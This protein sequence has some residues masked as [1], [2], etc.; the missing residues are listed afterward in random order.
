MEHLEEV[1]DMI[2]A[3]TGNDRFRDEYNEMTD[4][5]KKGEV[6]MCELYDR[7]FREGEEKGKAAKRVRMTLP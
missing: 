4:E 5:M 7:I 3:F 2:S 6:S 1:L